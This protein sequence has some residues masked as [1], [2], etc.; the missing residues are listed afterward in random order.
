MDEIEEIVEER[1]PTQEELEEFRTKINEWCKLDDQIK[2]LSIAIRERKKLQQAYAKFIKE[3]MFQFDYRDVNFEN[4]K[5]KAVS[6]EVRPPVKIT[7][8]K[9]KILEHNNLSGK[10]LLELIFDPE[11]REKITKEYIRRRVTMPSIKNLT[12]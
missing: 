12:L 8:I 3:F 5:I 7:E 2:K 1:Q 9:N 10:Q 4:S 6:T 11:K